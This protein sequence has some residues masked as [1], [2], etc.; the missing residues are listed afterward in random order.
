MAEINLTQTEADALIAM[1][2]VRENEVIHLFPV[3]GNGLI[4]PLFSEDRTENF[5]LDVSRG[6][7]NLLK[8]KY[9]TRVR[10][11]VVLVR[12]DLNGAPHRNPDDSE[13]ACPH[14]HVYREAYGDKWAVPAPGADFPRIDDLWHSLGDFMNFCHI[15]QP[16]HFERGLLV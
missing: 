15:T 1:P 6:R 7:I 13:I 8:A 2:K 11:V 14:L 12:L 5:L 9:Q 3:G 10:Q 16:P 4:I